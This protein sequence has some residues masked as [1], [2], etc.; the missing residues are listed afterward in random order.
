MTLT[1]LLQAVHENGHVFNMK[2]AYSEPKIY[3][4]GV[5]LEDWDM[6]PDEIRKKAL[7]K[8]WHVYFSFRHPE[9]GK[10]VRQKNQKAHANT[11]KTKEERMAVLE[12]L[13]R[14]LLFLLKNGFDP[15]QDNTHLIRKILGEDYLPKSIANRVPQPYFSGHYPEGRK[16]AKKVD[17]A[18]EP[19]VL[20][21]LPA[22]NFWNSTSTTDSIAEESVSEN[23][24][25]EE[26][27]VALDQRKINEISTP[28]QQNQG[29]QQKIN[30]KSTN[31]TGSTKN[32]QQINKP[33]TEVQPGGK[34]PTDSLVN[35]H[36]DINIISNN[37]QQYAVGRSEP[38]D[39]VVTIEEAISLAMSLKEKMLGADSFVKFKN[40][41]RK[42]EYWLGEN[43]Y[44]WQPVTAINKKVVVKYLNQVLM[45]T[46]PR[47][48]NNART[49]LSTVFQTMVDND[50]IE[51]NFIQDIN[52]LKA[53]PTRNKTYTPEQEQQLLKYIKENEP[54]LYVL[55][56]FII[57]PL[58]RPIEVCRLKIE[59]IDI[60]HKRVQLK[61]KN[62]KVKIKILPD[63]LLEELPD[64]S[65]YPKDS[66][67]I[68]PWGIGHA[69]GT[70]E[71]DKRNYFTG[72]YKKVKDHFGLG[73]EYGLYSWRHTSI[74]NLYKEMA[75]TMTPFEVKSKLLLITGHSSM[76][77]LE[78]YL[79]SI[80][81]QLPQ[82]YSHLFKK[83]GI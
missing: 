78:S 10:M 60:K 46:S 17:K 41:I 61:A 12:P 2:K 16:A 21:T 28:N 8:Y 22:N 29:D 43:G 48:R 68:T 44:A 74:T 18:P 67:L 23:V 33:D 32:Q 20:Q 3:T 83:P 9:T 36:T 5:K 31:A 80:D 51:Y 64:L 55:V 13:K 70:K 37:E 45:D 56:L 66:Y 81:A 19:V 40:R 25:S 34:N 15:Y 49:D 38:E 52:K 63:I 1:V 24:H 73:P 47:S 76:Q 11:F 27:S 6:L 53:L 77:A 50:L 59:D 30:E 4:G 39:G 65:K 35:G 42:F 79:R 71:S 72:K 58:L 62:K 54:T 7:E 26:R 75:K 82:D 14:N 69:W 57:Y